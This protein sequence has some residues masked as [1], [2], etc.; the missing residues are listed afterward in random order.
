MFIPLP[1]V[2]EAEQ[3]NFIAYKSSASVLSYEYELVFKIDSLQAS[4]LG[5]KIWI[6]ILWAKLVPLKFLLSQFMLTIAVKS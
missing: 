3:H 1:G 5:L 6:Y 2:H 4:L